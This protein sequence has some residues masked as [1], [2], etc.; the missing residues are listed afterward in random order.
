M[1]VAGAGEWL[2]PGWYSPGRWGC[3]EPHE[4]P[5][6]GDGR[7]MEVPEPQ[8]NGVSLWIQGLSGCGEVARAGR[9]V[10]GP[11]L[12]QTT[13]RCR[14]GLGPKSDPIPLGLDVP[15][16]PSLAP[17]S[18][19]SVAAGDPSANRRRP[20]QSDDHECQLIRSPVWYRM[21]GLGGHRFAARSL[22]GC[23]LDRRGTGQQDG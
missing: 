8:Q 11:M 22:P 3:H 13:S 23:D 14:L 17:C 10:G 2:G 19:L 20:G 7:A 4:R 16:H 18:L 21:F 1:L 6:T 9:A 12:D 15:R 5:G